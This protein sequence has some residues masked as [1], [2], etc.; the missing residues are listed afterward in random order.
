MGYHS[1]KFG[2]FLLGDV[3][4]AFELSLDSWGEQPNFI[5]IQT[6]I[7]HHVIFKFQ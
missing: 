3:G 6:A 5:S 7:L 2:A 4:L 1:Q